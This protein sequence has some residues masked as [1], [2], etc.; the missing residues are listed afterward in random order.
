MNPA[1]RPMLATLVNEPFDDKG[2]VFEIKWDGFRLIAE[3]RGDT[4]K[5]WSRNGVDVTKRYAVLLPAL[6]K[7]DVSC[8]IDGE[9]CALDAQ[10][11]S[12]FQLLQ[13]AL[14]KKARFTLCDFR[15]T[16]H[17]RQGHTPKAAA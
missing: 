2:W 8:V 12:R 3:K 1:Y 17:G 10:G 15:C 14:N 5:L 11:H 16:V 13:N 6:Q 7:I 4:V 9:L